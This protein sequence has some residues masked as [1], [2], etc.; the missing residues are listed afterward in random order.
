MTDKLSDFSVL[1][2]FWFTGRVLPVLISCCSVEKRLLITLSLM[3]HETIWNTPHRKSC[4][5]SI[6]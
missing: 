6:L 4:I 5:G 3:L 2:Q 1:L